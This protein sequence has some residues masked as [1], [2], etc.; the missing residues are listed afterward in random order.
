LALDAEDDAEVPAALEAPPA[1]VLEPVTD[2]VETAAALDTADSGLD[3]AELTASDDLSRY[4]DAGWPS[5]PGEG[6]PAVVAQEVLESVQVDATAP[7]PAAEEA[8][9][10]PASSLADG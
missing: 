9:A 10:E 8:D 3:V 4:F 6:E 7:L 1:Q 5:V 2:D